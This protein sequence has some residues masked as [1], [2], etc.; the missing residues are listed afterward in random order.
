MRYAANGKEEK[1][2]FLLL[3]QQDT[4]QLNATKQ[5]PNW[6]VANVEGQ[7]YYRVRYSTQALRNLLTEGGQRLTPAETIKL[8][9]DMQA[10]MESGAVPAQEAL[11]IAKTF[12]N[13]PQRQVVQRTMQLISSLETMRVAEGELRPRYAKL[14]STLYGERARTLG[15]STKEGEEAETRLLRASLVP[16]VATAGEDQALVAEAQRLAEK[17]LESKQGVDT[18]MLSSVLSTAARFGGKP[19]FERMLAVLR[20]TQ[21]R[22]Q[23]SYLF[24]ALGNF[25][26]PALAQT[27]MALLLTDEFDIR[28][29]GPLLFGPAAHSE[30]RT[31]PFAFVQANFDALVRRSPTGTSFDFGARLPQVAGS[32]CDAASLAEVER[33]FTERV[34]RFTGG[35]RVLSQTLESGRLCASLRESQQASA[36]EFLQAN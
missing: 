13:S 4:L 14:V 10:L 25:R 29:A 32:Y 7:G 18:D 6:L 34:Q 23:R 19:L 17:W 3:E 20:A 31:L 36:R 8:L 15:W 22:Q 24:T 27:G 11:T 26:D 12:A 9:G 16:F 33:F 5:C 1:E 30:T 28:E 21:D 2:C 35:P